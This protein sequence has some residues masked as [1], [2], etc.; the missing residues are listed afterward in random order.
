M[1]R[2][3][4]CRGF[5]PAHGYEAGVPHRGMLLSALAAELVTLLTGALIDLRASG[6]DRY[7][8]RMDNVEQGSVQHGQADQERL[9]LHDEYFGLNLQ[10]SDSAAPI[11]TAQPR[12]PRCPRTPPPGD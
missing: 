4:P 1:R 5:E 2:F 12:R 10:V 9:V 11:S 3:E 8:A 6:A 7:S